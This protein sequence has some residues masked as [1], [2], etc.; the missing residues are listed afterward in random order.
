MG[1]FSKALEKGKKTVIKHKVKGIV[2]EK[3]SLEGQHDDKIDEFSDKVIEKIGV[4]NII[5]AKKL[6]DK[7]DN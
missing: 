5:K 2:N 1:L 6:I 7:L 3:L 4:D